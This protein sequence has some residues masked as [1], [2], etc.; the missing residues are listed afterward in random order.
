MIWALLEPIGSLSYEKKPE[1]FI[2]Y[3]KLGNFQFNT[4][5]KKKWGNF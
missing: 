1:H 2:I 4:K 5:K 3:L